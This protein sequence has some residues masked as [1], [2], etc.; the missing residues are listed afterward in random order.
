MSFD[1][2][3]TR[4]IQAWHPQWFVDAMRWVAWLSNT[5]GYFI[6][7]PVVAAFLVWRGRK[8]LKWTSPRSS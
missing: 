1:V 7:A 5:T 2:A 8:R 3:V 4:F 6:I